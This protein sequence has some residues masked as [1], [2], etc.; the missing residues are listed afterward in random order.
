[1]DIV[2]CL[3]Q[4][5]DPGSVEIDP[6]TGRVEEKRSVYVTHPADLSALEAALALKEQ[7]GGRVSVLSLGPA[8]TER[9]LREAW[10]MGAD[11]V[12]R[13]WEDDWE[14]V[15][16]P[17]F[18]AFALAYFIKKMPCDLVL[19]GDGGGNFHASE[20]PAWLAEYLHL[21]FITGVVALHR[22]EKLQTMTVKRKLEKGKRQVLRCELPALLALSESFS[23]PRR[24]AMPDLLAVMQAEIPV[25]PLLLGTVARMIPPHVS[26]DMIYQVRPLRPPAQSIDSPDCSLPGAERINR[27]V[28]GGMSGKKSELVQGS[29]EQAARAMVAFLEAADL[30][31][32][33]SQEN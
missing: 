18:V 27:V 3:K 24:W 20:V 16:A 21:P 12:L 7:L 14:N 25:A 29:P 11:Q 15:C 10:A 6:G 4:V 5:A 17:H 30:I 13:I 26:R 8:R 31:T 33:R 2:V 32:K 23:Q 1:M 9:S 22:E 19:C 28:S